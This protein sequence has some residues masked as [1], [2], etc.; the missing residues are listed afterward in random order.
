MTK[1]ELTQVMVFLHA[2][3]DAEVKREKIEV[4]FN[5]FG[6]LP[7]RP[8]RIAARVLSTRK[9]FGVPKGQDLSSAIREILQPEGRE[10]SGA[11]AFQ[12]AY[13]AAARFGYTRRDAG[14]KSLPPLVRRA[15]ERFGWDDLR[16]AE[17]PELIRGQFARVYESISAQE[18]NELALPPALKEE[19]RT[20]RAEAMA[21]RLPGVHAAGAIAQR[22]VKAITDGKEG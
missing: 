21:G 4:W 16:M 14:L 5:A 19:I 20:I 9:S 11:E 6:H 10:I 7:T 17:N 22:I 8:V 3:Y 18:H 1:A 2:D 15:A 12:M 13:A